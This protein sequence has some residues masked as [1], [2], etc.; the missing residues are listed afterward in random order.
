MRLGEGTLMANIKVAKKLS[1]TMASGLRPGMY[2]KGDWKE[3]YKITKVK[4]VGSWV[5][6]TMEGYPIVCT[7]QHDVELPFRY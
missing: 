3:W 7:I 6:V 1:M 2:V 5:F 4:T